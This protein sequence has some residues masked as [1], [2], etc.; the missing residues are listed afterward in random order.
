MIFHNAHFYIDGSF[1]NRIKAIKV[2][3]GKISQLMESLPSQL[4]DQTLDLQG[5]F[6]YPG[7]IDCHT[8]SISGG[9]Y[10]LGVNLAA[11]ADIASL[12]VKI[13][14]HAQMQKAGAL[15]FAWNFDENSLKEKRFPSQ[16]EIDE[17]C[18][19]KLLLF[20]RI[21]G[22]SCMISSNA[23]AKIKA[24][25]CKD[26]V[27]TGAENDL[28]TNWFHS[29]LD[30]EAVMKAYQAAA[31]VAMQGGFTTVHTMIGDADMSIDHF[32]LLTNQLHTL[33]IEYI[34]YPQS[35]NIDAALAAGSPRIGGC[36]LADGSIGSHTAALSTPYQDKATRGKLY[37]TDAFWK[38]FITKAHQNKLQV[39]VHCIGDAAIKQINDIY[40]ELE[41]TQ[42]QDL[43]H[44]LIHCELCPDELLSQI[45]AS[46]ANPVM[47]SA[48]DLYWG[49]PNG[50]Y[51]QRLGSSRAKLMNRF[52][53]FI[54]SKIPV[55]GSSDWYVTPMNIAMSIYALIHH[56]NP[57][58]R[59]SAQD[60]INIYTKNAARLSHDEKRLGKLQAGFQADLSVL[61]TDLTLPFD[62]HAVRTKY[63]V[64]KGMQVYAYTPNCS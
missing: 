38:D 6:A 11:C 1:E 22:H 53:S 10:T 7:F 9:I 62:F 51:E 17:L 50:L 43:R 49:K 45:K 60:A 55:C 33:P 30:V 47:Q 4:V 28:V 44:Q 3:D 2:E 20:R 12:K 35:F 39:A 42:P 63:I 26:Q 14:R 25:K 59:I 57:L 41:R 37:Q 23:R 61:D 52:A 8:H 16:E 58:E 24:L 32:T 48:F 54:K 13:S 46:G 27:L 36:I 15:I 64:K 18:Q 29:Q 40:L 34:L 19:D 56:H 31:E 5:G 21:D